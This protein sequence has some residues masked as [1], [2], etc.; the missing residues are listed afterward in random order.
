MGSG[1]PCPRSEKPR[2]GPHS[3]SLFRFRACKT[4]PCGS[5]GTVSPKVLEFVHKTLTCIRIPWSFFKCRPPCLT[6]EDSILVRLGGRAGCE[7]S[8]RHSMDFRTSY[9]SCWKITELEPASG[10]ASPGP[11][12]TVSASKA[13]SPSELSSSPK[14]QKR[15]SPQKR[16]E[17][18]L[19]IKNRPSITPLSSLASQKT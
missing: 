7:H 18:P 9:A 4:F 10:L 14:S 5:L 6:S 17:V 13:R 2:G 19:H 11:A 12:R 15:L 16:L 8:I 3:S 1:R